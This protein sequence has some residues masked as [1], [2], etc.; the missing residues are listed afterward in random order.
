MNRRRATDVATHYASY[1]LNTGKIL[2]LYNSLKHSVIP[3]NRVEISVATR[4]AILKTPRAYS[5]DLG[6]R[7]VV[8]TEAS[9]EEST[10]IEP[11]SPLDAGIEHEGLYYSVD[12]MS[13]AYLFECLSLAAFDESRTFQVMAFKDGKPVAATIDKDDL[14][15]IL[16]KLS[17]AQGEA[18]VEAVN[19][20]LAGDSDD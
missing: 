3:I 11:R 10:Q 18:V 16:R 8:K 19:A 17:D 14:L 2:G 15:A 7:N 6:K 5:V 12:S 13:R 9:Q 20:R 4:D 1:D